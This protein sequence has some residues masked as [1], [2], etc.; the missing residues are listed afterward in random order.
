MTE[1]RR[2]VLQSSISQLHFTVRSLSGQTKEKEDNEEIKEKGRLRDKSK[3]TNIAFISGSET[4]STSWSLKKT[5]SGCAC[6]CVCV[7]VCV[8]VHNFSF[9]IHLNGI[10]LNHTD[11]WASFPDQYL[12]SIH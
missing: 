3:T 4:S 10:L 11:E 7:C 1:E 9:L 5:Q 12:L 2:D 8:S 6:V